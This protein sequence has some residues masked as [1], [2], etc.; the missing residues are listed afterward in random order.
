MS[1]TITRRAAVTGLAA[2]PAAALAGS[3]PAISAGNPEVTLWSPKV[4]G[5]V[6]K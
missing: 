3:L 2:A 1:K 5:L 6:F 4:M